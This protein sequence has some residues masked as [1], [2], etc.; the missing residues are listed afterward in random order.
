MGMPSRTPCTHHRLPWRKG[1]S[2]LSAGKVCS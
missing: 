1:D 2:A